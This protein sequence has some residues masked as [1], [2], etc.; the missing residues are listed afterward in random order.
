MQNS[1][2]PVAAV[3]RGRLDQRRDVEPDRAHR[4]V[5]RPDW[6]QKWQSSGQPPVLSETM[7]STSTS[8]PHQRIRTSWASAS[9]SSTALVGQLQDLERLRLVEAD[10][11]LEHL[12]AGD[13]EDVMRGSSRF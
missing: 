9:A 13:V 10:A 12:L 8:G 5:E 6:Q 4:R 11:P 2:A 7:P 1:V 3:C